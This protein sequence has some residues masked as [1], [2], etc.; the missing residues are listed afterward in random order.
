M[1]GKNLG[2]F[3]ANGASF[4]DIMHQLWEKFSGNIKGQAT[5]V[6]ETW[7]VETPT[8]V[9]WNSVMPPGLAVAPHYPQTQNLS[10]LVPLVST[11]AFPGGTAFGRRL[12][13]QYE[14]WMRERKLSRV[15]LMI[16]LYRLLLR[17]MIRF[18]QCQTLKSQNTKSRN[19]TAF[20]IFK[21]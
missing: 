15:T 21:R 14:H 18:Q 3:A 16:F 19:I 17:C 11:Y 1:T 20:S 2:G 6:N 5:L 9:S 12:E 10:C 7:S 4:D 8:E 13:C